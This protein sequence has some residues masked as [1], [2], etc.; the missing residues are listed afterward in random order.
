[1]TVI[2]PDQIEIR[3][4][5]SRAGSQKI[6]FLGTWR[7]TQRQVVVKQFLRRDATA[8]RELQSFPLTLSHR[9]IIETHR[10]QNQL[11]EL[12]L[13]EDLLPDVLNDDWHIT[14]IEDAANFLHDIGSAI[15]HIH[16]HGLVHGDIK[17]DNIGRRQSDYILLDFGICRP[18]QEFAAEASATGSLRTRAPELLATDRYIDPPKVDI[19]A[20]GATLFSAYKERFP[21]LERHERVPRISRPEE[22]EPFE[23]ELRRR[24]TEEWDQRV[25]FSGIPTDLESVLRLALARDPR[26]RGTS[27]EVLTDVE[28]RLSA[29]IRTTSSSA[30]ATWRFSPSEELE[31]ISDYLTSLPAGL[32]FPHHKKSALRKRLLDLQTIPGFSPEQKE[33]ARELADRCSSS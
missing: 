15:K 17:P 27:T 5:L 28:R 13:V 29:F 20:L 23:A 12:F 32:P 4:V 22:R 14:G 31:Q 25:E 2:P 24:V 8:D 7:L 3:K 9:H 6:V 19:W 1:M 30:L 16:D 10:L 18:I 11:G 33:H 26:M 21:L